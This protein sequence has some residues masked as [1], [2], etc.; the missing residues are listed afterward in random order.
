M[1]DVRIVGNVSAEMMRDR[2]MLA[3]SGRRVQVADRAGDA[4]MAQ[5]RLNGPQVRSVLQ[6][7]CGAAMAQ[8]V[9]ADGLGKL[10][11]EGGGPDQLEDGRPTYLLHRAV[12]EDDPRP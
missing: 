3:R 2:H 6:Q 9:A 4:A 8:R 7:M 1:P 12:P 5:E 11:L 10:R